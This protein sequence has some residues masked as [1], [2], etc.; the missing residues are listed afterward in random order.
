MD[1]STAIRLAVTVFVRRHGL[2][3]AGAA[4]FIEEA[5]IPLP[6]LPGDLVMLAVGIQARQGTYPLWLAIAVME[7][8][9]FAGSALLYYASR[10]AGRR[11]L[12]RYGRLLRVTPERLAR[13]EEWA[14]GRGALA[15]VAGRLIP[16]LRIL[17]AIGCGAL[18]MPPRTF[19]PAMALGSLIYIS[20]YAVLGFVVGPAAQSVLAAAHVSVGTLG[21]AALL[22]VVAVWIAR[23]RRQ[24]GSRAVR[25]AVL[26]DSA[27][28]HRRQAT[29]GLS[30][31]AVASLTAALALNALA[32]V[33][34]GLALLAPG[35]VPWVVATRAPAALARRGDAAILLTGAFL[36]ML[37]GALWGA[38]YGRWVARLAR[39][40]RLADWSGGALFAVAPFVVGLLVGRVAGSS[41]LPPS[42]AT[43]LL[44]SDVV[45]HV[46]FGATLGLTF[47]I[48][49]IRAGS[50][51]ERPQVTKQAREPAVRGYLSDRSD[52]SPAP[53][54]PS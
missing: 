21:S 4:L 14:R 9:S 37:V 45:F 39:R 17:T 36:V 41:G 43:A 19:L 51:E 44:T 35:T 16:G 38:A 24:L 12:L 3:A 29:A 25:E 28:A 18:E 11:L 52:T 10:R 40:A 31:G 42:A 27:E 50:R 26:G 23:T 13:A 8:A 15:V 53:S 32:P 20:L 22:V 5:G 33:V 6:L 7:A 34:G 1:W 54:R 2:A 47:P 49:A 30:A 46:A 48:L